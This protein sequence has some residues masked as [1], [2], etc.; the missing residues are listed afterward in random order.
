MMRNYRHRANDDGSKAEIDGGALT[1]SNAPIHIACALC[2]LVLVIAAYLALSLHF[3]MAGMADEF[4]AELADFRATTERALLAL[5]A[6]S[7]GG[8]DDVDGSQRIKR[9]YVSAPSYSSYASGAPQP[10]VGGGGYAKAPSVNC[11]M[12]LFVLKSY[13]QQ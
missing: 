11:R 1:A 6:D 9:Q 2:A 3:E 13:I 7:D 5:H 10:Y 8:G 12:Y 4:G